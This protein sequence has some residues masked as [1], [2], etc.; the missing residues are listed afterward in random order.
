LVLK[1]NGEII[2]EMPDDYRMLGYYSVVSGNEIHIIDNDPYSLSRN[3]GLTDVSL[4]EKYKISDEAYDKR[5]GTMREYIRQQRMQDP[6]FKLKPASNA[7]KEP[8]E[9]PG[10]ESVEGIKV[11]DRCEVMPGA[12]RGVVRYVGEIAAISAGGYWVGVQFDEPVGHNNGSVKG[13][14]IFSCPQGYGAFIRG[15]NI[16]VGDYPE[17]DPFASDDEDCACNEATKS[18]ANEDEI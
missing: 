3:G 11:G 8:K 17:R 12:R 4:V 9:A 10:P 6:N 2:C 1:S 15:N 14:Q 13:V 16:T 18:E 7:P 5:K